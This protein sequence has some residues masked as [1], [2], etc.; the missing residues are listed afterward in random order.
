MSDTALAFDTSGP[1]CAVAVLR[2]SEVLAHSHVD[3]TRGQAEALLPQI[4][5]TMAECGVAWSDIDLIGVGTGPGNF[6]GVRIAV[7]AARGLAMGLGIKAVGV[8][9]LD[10]QATG[11]D[12]PV[13]S[14]A[15]AP[16]DRVYVQP[17]NMGTPSEPELHPIAD[18]PALPAPAGT[19]CVGHQADTIGAAMGWQPLK[20]PHPTVVGIAMRAQARKDSATTRPAPVYLRPADAAPPSDPPPVIL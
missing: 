11:I 12:G 20:Q 9:I 7:S 4:E 3:M 5:A 16:R 17:M 6:T 18:I 15:P 1:Y 14:L 13:V 10:A 2:G 8:S 19:T